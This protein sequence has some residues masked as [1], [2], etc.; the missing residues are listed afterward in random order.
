MET[1]TRPCT[2]C[3]KNF[4]YKVGKYPRHR[5]L[6]CRAIYDRERW[7][8][9]RRTA[10]NGLGGCCVRCGFDDWRAL[11]VDHIQPL[12][13]TS[14]HDGELS[15]DVIRRIERG[16]TGN[17]QLLCANCNWIKRYENDEVAKK[18]G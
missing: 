9:R 18:Y 16:D 2:I 7:R 3:G 14:K 1:K 6:Y 5:C 13:R 4:T 12:M 17:L 11:Q 15:R 10:I 8:R